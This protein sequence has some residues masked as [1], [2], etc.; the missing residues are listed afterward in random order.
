MVNALGHLVAMCRAWHRDTLSG[1]PR[2]HW[3]RNVL[4]EKQLEAATLDLS[5]DKPAWTCRWTAK[6]TSN[7]TSARAIRSRRHGG[8]RGRWPKRSRRAAVNVVAVPTPTTATAPTNS[9]T[10]ATTEEATPAQ[11]ATA[12]VTMG[13]APGDGDV[14]PPRFS[15]SGDIY[16]AHI[17]KPVYNTTQRAPARHSATKACLQ[18]K[19][20]EISTET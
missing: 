19:P 13:I 12:Y 4:V 3:W 11:V 1:S 2:S 5:H 18:L 15:F 9:A 14:L 10:T 17:G 16:N 7:Y 8:W 20:A 6:S